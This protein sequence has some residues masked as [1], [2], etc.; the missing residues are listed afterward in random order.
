MR[1]HTHEFLNKSIMVGTKV[2]DAILCRMHTLRPEWR[3]IDTLGQAELGDGA[4]CYLSLYDTLSAF[5][6]IH[7]LVMLV[8]PSC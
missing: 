3:S 7:L 6:I 4:T 5:W 1:H 8:V 2:C